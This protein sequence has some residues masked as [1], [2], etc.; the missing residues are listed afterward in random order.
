VEVVVNGRVVAAREGNGA[1]KLRL[2]FRI[3][4]QESSWVAARAVAQFEGKWPLQAHTNA[5]YVLREGRPVAVGDARQVLQRRWEEQARYYL[6]PELVFS[7]EAHRRQLREN[8]EAAARV[9]SQGTR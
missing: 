7:Q 8:V 5:V 2:P 1:N 6:G 9:L 3:A 4:I